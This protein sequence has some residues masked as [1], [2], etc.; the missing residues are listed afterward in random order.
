M[1]QTL[2]GAQ[3]FKAPNVEQNMAS[4]VIG[5]NSE[6]FAV[7]DI[8]TLGTD[9]LYVAGATD[10]VIG[11]AATTATMASTNE[12]VAKVKPSYIPISMDYEFLMGT[13]SDMS[14]LTSVGAYYSLVAGGTGAQQVDTNGGA[15][16]TTNR[17]VICTAVDPSGLGGTGSG[18]G[19]RQG[20]FKFVKIFNVKSNT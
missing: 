8:L 13:N 9:G 15:K 5:K 3:L 19:L 12:T 4:N 2:Y 11:V 16:T 17:V 18:S 10:S 1:A 7:G 6:V 14:A 20:L